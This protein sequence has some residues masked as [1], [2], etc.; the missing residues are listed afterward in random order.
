MGDSIPHVP[1]NVQHV[2][3]RLVLITQRKICLVQPGMHINVIK[4]PDMRRG[5]VTATMCNEFFRIRI[6]MELL[7]LTMEGPSN[8]LRSGVLVRIIHEEPVNP[9]LGHMLNSPRQ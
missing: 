5:T 1:Y 4:F 3:I 7:R 6:L 8:A 2:P 9:G